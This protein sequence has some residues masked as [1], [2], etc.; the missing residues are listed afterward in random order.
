MIE[1]LL[2]D[3]EIAHVC[4]VACHKNPHWQL[5]AW[6][7]YDLVAKAA[8]LKLLEWGKQECI[9]HKRIAKL[10]G[11]GSIPDATFETYETHFQCPKC[12]TELES[13]LKEG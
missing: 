11:M 12:M 13:K 4:R 9:E 8:Q 7:L 1:G 10:E 3:K 2:T 5:D 6:G